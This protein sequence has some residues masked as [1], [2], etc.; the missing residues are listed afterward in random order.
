MDIH[1]SCL[2]RGISFN[3]NERLKVI[4]VSIL[5]IFLP[6]VALTWTVEHSLIFTIIAT[7]S[8]EIWWTGTL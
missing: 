8:S 5:P 1:N 7:F 2:I 3:Q 6:F 4:F